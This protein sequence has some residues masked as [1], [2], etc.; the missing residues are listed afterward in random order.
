MS[1]V[2][3]LPKGTLRNPDA[4]D[5]QTLFLMQK[6]FRVI[7]HNR[8]GHGR[9]VGVAHSNYWLPFLYV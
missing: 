9:G 6:G 3:L 8:R 5:G 1:I 4:W 2:A 7:A